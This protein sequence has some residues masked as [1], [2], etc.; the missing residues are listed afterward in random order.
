LDQ[1]HP[2]TAA[3]PPAC[4]T[5]ALIL[6]HVLVHHGVPLEEAVAKLPLLKQAMIDHFIANEQQAGEGLELL[7][8]V[9]P[10]LQKLATRPDVALCLVTGNLEPIGKPVSPMN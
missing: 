2:S 4:S 7:P 6:L 9:L 10:L 5:D 1:W 8:G 3:L